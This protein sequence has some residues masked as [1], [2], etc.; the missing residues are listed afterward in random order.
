MY[1]Y[2]I[3][4]LLAN[5]GDNFK[6]LYFRCDIRM[7]PDWGKDI[8]RLL[9]Y[10][11]EEDSVINYIMESIRISVNETRKASALLDVMIVKGYS[12]EFD[13]DD[14]ADIFRA[15]VIVGLHLALTSEIYTESDIDNLESNLMSVVMDP[16]R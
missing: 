11:I 15:G 10:F 8:H 6:K 1:T 16:Y 13:W 12:Y 9:A 3:P 4:S 5:I 7:S 14:P 2:D